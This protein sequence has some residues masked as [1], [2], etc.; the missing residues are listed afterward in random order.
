MLEFSQF[1]AV[2]DFS[3]IFKRRDFTDLCEDKYNKIKFFQSVS[4][5]KIT[6][7]TQKKPLNL[8]ITS[9]V[10]I[11]IKLPN[12]IYIYKKSIQMKS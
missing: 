7:I 6:H 8:F 3:H 1:T 12:S 10:H 9:S 2:F 11:S 5:V 4:F